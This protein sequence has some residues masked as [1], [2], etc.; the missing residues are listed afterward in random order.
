MA[1]RRFKAPRCRHGVARFSASTGESL[2]MKPLTTNAVKYGQILVVFLVVAAVAVLMNEKALTEKQKLEEK[3]IFLL[4]ESERIAGEIKFLERNVTLLRSDVKT[5]EKVA[6]RKL[7]MA[8][9]DETIYIFQQED[10]HLGQGDNSELTLH[11]EANPS[12][13]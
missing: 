11:N 12:L 6:K 7:G 8:R 9:P 13:F 3:R 1:P 10:Q 5:I 4:K 2:F